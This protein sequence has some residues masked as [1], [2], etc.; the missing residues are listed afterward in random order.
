MISFEICLSIMKVERFLR[1]PSM[2]W[3]IGLKSP[4]SE[5]MRFLSLAWQG[6]VNPCTREAPMQ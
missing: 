2:R 5:G 4:I 3:N 1:Y 6:Y